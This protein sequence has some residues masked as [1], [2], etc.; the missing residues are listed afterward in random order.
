MVVLE[1]DPPVSLL[2]MVQ[3]FGGVLDRMPAVIE[4]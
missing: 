3:A 4:F 1:F 2:D